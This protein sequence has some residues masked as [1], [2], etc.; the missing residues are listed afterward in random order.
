VRAHRVKSPLRFLTCRCIAAN[1]AKAPTVNWSGCYAG[2]NGGGAASGSDLTSSLKTGTYLSDPADIA[3]VAKIS[4]SSINDSRFIGGG[5]VGCNIQSGTFVLGVEGDW[6]S[7]STKATA[8]SS[9]LLVSG[10]SF[11]ITNSVTANWLSTIRP[12]VGIAAGS[13]FIYATGGIA[14]ANFGFTQ[15]YADTAGAAGSASA[16]RMP[17]PSLRSPHAQ[18]RPG[19][20]RKPP[21]KETAGEWAPLSAGAME[22][23]LATTVQRRCGREA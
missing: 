1:R 4:P 16:S 2:I 15:T 12:R 23:S 6:D 14:F 13:S 21:V 3:A 11:S 18:R 5:Q 7:L 22:I 20:V 19:R 8:T 10:D 9:G 17:A